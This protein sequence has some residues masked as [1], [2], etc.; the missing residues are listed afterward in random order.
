MSKWRGRNETKEEEQFQLIYIF[1]VVNKVIVRVL[2]SEDEIILERIHT[3]K[4]PHL[5]LHTMPVTCWD[6]KL[7]THLGSWRF[8]R[9]VLVMG[10]CMTLF[11]R[12]KLCIIG[13]TIVVVKGFG[14]LNF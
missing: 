11:S 7:E 13:S 4:N 5:S 3:Q 9:F 2:S 10:K 1:L 8:V 12:C 6:Q 14:S